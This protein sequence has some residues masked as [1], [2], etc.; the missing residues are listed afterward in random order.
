[1]LQDIQYRYS[2]KQIHR[3]VDERAAVLD[4]LSRAE[5]FLLGAS[6][7]IMHLKRGRE[8]R[9][10]TLRWPRTDHPRGRKGWIEVHDRLVGR[11][12]LENRRDF[13]IGWHSRGGRRFDEPWIEAEYRRW[14]LLTYCVRSAC[15]SIVREKKTRNDRV[16]MDDEYKRM[17]RCGSWW[18]RA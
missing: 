11:H 8:N 2:P 10:V 12:V 13:R 14:W 16:V 15:D 7:L 9:N 5:W 3:L 6:T 1:M 17:I 18:F 4:A